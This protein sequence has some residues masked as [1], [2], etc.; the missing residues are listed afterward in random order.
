MPP[1]DDLK[2]FCQNLAV[3]GDKIFLSFANLADYEN[4]INTPQFDALVPRLLIAG[5]KIL[6]VYCPTYSINLNLSHFV[7]TEAAI[8]RDRNWGST[9]RDKALRTLLRA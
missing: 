4:F 3:T 2:Q 6:G 1:I 5:Y 9:R 8:R 7:I